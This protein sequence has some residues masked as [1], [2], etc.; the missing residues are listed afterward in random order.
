MQK[1]DYTIVFV[2]EMARSV[3]FYRDVLGLPLRFDS[4]TWTEFA[5]EGTT[6][7]LHLAEAGDWSRPSPPFPAASCHPGFQVGD[8]DEF[9][10]KL[11]AQGVPCLDPPKLQ[12]FGVKLAIYADPDG[13]PISISQVVQ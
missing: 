1:V 10:R 9:H 12:D 13:L 8:I 3:R 2:S 4:P 6:L 11:E 5:T 7:A